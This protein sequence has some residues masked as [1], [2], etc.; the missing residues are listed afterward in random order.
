MLL[1]IQGLDYNR[2][3]LTH[4]ASYDSTEGLAWNHINI[5]FLSASKRLSF[6]YN[7]EETARITQWY[8]CRVG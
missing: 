2:L 4:G 5:C 6:T 1:I 8:I 3:F 7:S